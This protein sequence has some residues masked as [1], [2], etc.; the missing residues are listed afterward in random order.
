M[1][2]VVLLIACMCS[3]LFLFAQRTITGRVL[4]EKGEPVPSASVQVRGSTTGTV[5]GADGRY[6][7][8][9]PAG[10]RQLEFSNV[11]MTPQIVDIKEG[12]SV[13][14]V[15]LLPTTA[16]LEE[17]VVTGFSRVRRSEYS[18]ASS[19]V[20]EKE[21]KNVPMGS[22]DQMLQG[23]APGLT[24]LSGN[25]Q[26]GS[27]ANVILRGPT[28]ITGGSTP[29]YVVDGIPIEGDAF[30]GINPNDIVTVDVLKDASAS[31]MYGSRGAAG[32]IVVTTKR[33]ESGKMKLGVSSQFGIKSKPDFKYDMMSTS[34]LLQAQE[35]LGLV[36]PNSSLTAWGT[37]PTLPG[38]QYSRNNPNKLVGGVA[39]PKT[40]ADYEFGDRQLDS[41][42]RVNT[43]WYD[44]FYRNGSFSN[45]EISFSGGTGKTRIYSNLGL[46]NEQGINKP[47]DMKRV[48]LRNNM[49][50][51]DEKLTFSM[52][53][54]IGYTRRNF[55]SNN[56][57]SFNTFVNPFFVPMVTPSYIGAV[58]PD[59][60]YN[61]GGGI[62]YSAPTQLDKS[63]YDKVYNDQIKAILSMNVNY[64]FTK[65]IYAGFQTG[66]DFRHTQNTTYND[67]RV[68]D[69]YTN[70]NVRTKTGSMTEGYNRLVTLNARGNVGY[71]NTFATDHDIDVAVYGE[72]LA[73]YSKTLTATGFGIDPRRPNTIAAIT[74]GNAANQLFQTIGGGRTRSVLE[75]VMS[76][77]RYS[78]KK[79]YTVTGTFRRDGTSMLPTQNRLKDFWNVGGI[80]ETGREAFLR[81]SKV[82]NQLRIK[83]SYGQSANANNFPFGNFGYR[84]LYNTQA[85]LISG[86]TGI[87]PEVTAPGNPEADWEYTSTANLGIEFGLFKNRLYGDVQVYNKKTNNLFASL[88]LSA[89]GGPFGAVDVNAGSM[90]NRGIEY[91]LNYDVIKNRDMIWSVYVNGAYNK[92]KV[93]S[94]GPLTSFELGTSLISVGL[95]LGSHYEVKW[96]GVDASTGAPLYYDLDG[97]VTPVYST[98]NSVQEFG[99]WIPPYTGGFGT[100]LSYKG[101]DI[102]A[103]FSYAAKTYRVNNLE[104]FVESTNFLAQGIN[105]ARSLNFWKKPGDVAS[106]QSPLYQNQFTSKLIQDASFLRLRNVTL[107]YSMPNTV[108]EKLKHVS[109]IRIYMVGQ[110]LLT[111]T[112]WK[113]LDP[114]DDNNISLSEYPN[115][116][117]I[118]AGIEVRF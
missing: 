87:I 9:I 65:N 45:N 19:K 36:T 76:T 11:G 100:S 86:N 67:P 64:N 106:S 59:G 40:Q 44:Y 60:K 79:K 20:T 107:S 43:N 102:S 10:A 13:Y 78:F 61:A 47:S 103:S 111:W 77:A 96:A 112:K 42:G 85:N 94:L 46:Y 93:T 63:Q 29:L 37:F 80:W 25:G 91:T 38:W 23:K 27:T 56:L 51:A 34:E 5:T 118:T 26:P 21:L 68:Y 4:N 16:N 58:R 49:D 89:T 72:Y 70:A 109:S 90:Y 117:A 12:V 8:S 69:T 57:N 98:A 1:K 115:P 53:S 83:M 2:K 41:I 97:K 116:R 18:G 33:G 74:A 54:N 22:F 14:S 101:F 110:N 113:G 55:Q 39:V 48:T 71:R 75:S 73:Y 7:L 88:S 50:Y 66:V 84:S 6:S 24:V 81:G 28:S 30:Q 95:P 82:I 35:Q 62:I 3:V 114:E 52:S 92:N 108:L 104:F 15:S 17:V 105:Q 31:A 99:T 32:V